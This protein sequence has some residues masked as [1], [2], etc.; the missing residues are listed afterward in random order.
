METLP[1]R[2]ATPLILILVCCQMTASSTFAR[3]PTFVVLTE[4]RTIQTF[5][6]DGMLLAECALE[7]RHDIPYRDAHVADALVDRPGDELVLLRN[8]HKLDLYPDP[9]EQAGELKRIGFVNLGRALGADGAPQERR[10]S[11]ALAPVDYD[12]NGANGPEWLSMTWKAGARTEARYEIY[13]TLRLSSFMEP[14]DHANLPPTMPAPAESASV[15][16]TSLLANRTGCEL[17]CIAGGALYGVGPGTDDTSLLFSRPIRETAPGETLV[18][19]RA[20][21]KQ[22]VLLVASGGNASIEFYGVDGTRKPERVRTV[23]LQT[24]KP[25]LA[26][27]TPGFQASCDAPLRH[28]LQGGTTLLF[29]TEAFPGAG[30]WKPDTNAHASGN[31]LLRVG[32][33]GEAAGDAKTLV[34]IP[35]EGKYHVWARGL[36]MPGNQ[37]GTRRFRVIVD[38]ELSPGEGGRHGRDG[39]AWDRVMTVHLEAGRHML[40][41]HDSA[42]FYA[43]ADAVLLTTTDMNPN[44]HSMEQLVTYRKAPEPVKQQRETPLADLPVPQ[45]ASGREVARLQ[46]DRLRMIFEMRQA[47]DGSE[48]IVR[49]TQILSDRKVW[50]ESVSADSERLFVLYAPDIE[51]YYRYFPFWDDGDTIDLKAQG[52]SYRIKAPDQDNP[53]TAGDMTPFLPVSARRT[54]ETTVRVDY[55]ASDGQTLI[56][57]WHLEPDRYDAEVEVAYT[58]QRTGLYSIGFTGFQNWRQDEIE[59]LHLPPV[60]QYQRLPQ[61]PRLLPHTYMPHPLALLQVPVQEKGHSVTVALAGDTARI[62][63]QWPKVDNT[64]YGFS[65]LNSEADPQPCIFTPVLGLGD[66]RWQAGEQHTVGWRVLTYPGEWEEAFEYFSESMMKVEDYRS[67]VNVSLTDA[68]L[69]MIELMRDK[70]HAGWDDELKG[71]YN[72]EIKGTVTQ[73][74]P[75]A[76]LSA[77]ILARDEELYASRAL[78]TIAYTLSRRGPHFG[79]PDAE[80]PST[81]LTIP[82]RAYGTPYWEGVNELLGH[83]NPWMVREFA[84]PDGEARTGRRL[85]PSYTALLGAWRADPSP[86]RLD[87]VRRKADAYIRKNYH[88]RFEKPLAIS[89]FSNV[90]NYPYWWDLVDLYEIT[91]ERDYLDYAAEGGFHTMMHLWSHPLHPSGTMRIHEGGQI[92]SIAGPMLKGDETY[93]LGWPRKPGDTPERAVPAWQV[94]PVGLGIENN[95]T[96]VQ[97]KKQFMRNIMMENWAPHLLRLF[98]HTGRDIYRTYARNSIIGRFA[99][100]PGYYLAMFTDLVQDPSYP[101]TGPD[102]TNIYYHHI[103]PHLMFSL[104]YLV[105]Q[106]AQR[107]D[108]AV[109]FP[110]AKQQNYVWFTNRVYGPAAGTICG[111]KGAVLWL[112]KDLLRQ[113]LDPR[114]DWLAARSENRFFLIL[115][116]QADAT[117]KLPLPLNREKVGLA[118]GQVRRYEGSRSRL[119]TLSAKEAA[120]VTLPARG[121][122][123]LSFP[124]EPRALFPRARAL[125][126]GHKARKIDSKWGTLHAFRIRTPFGRDSLYM[127]LTG[128]PDTADGG[129]TFE[130][131][132]MPKTRHKRKRFPYESTVYPLPMERDFTIRVQLQDGAETAEAHLDI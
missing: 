91:G 107:S 18:S 27:T 88:R 19:V 62:P 38:G 119:R 115:M 65:L 100:Y 81:Q 123:T 94:S 70:A 102:V 76:V 32:G 51:L 16:I 57:T 117:L 128:G 124:A 122:V 96:L 8:D 44:E 129:V 58:P 54:D 98:Q 34:D 55:R 41:L 29:E 77:A 53:F 101:Y 120:S 126:N 125:Q 30:G 110:Y 121:I 1:R 105:A 5:S 104:D 131:S 47:S 93:R 9:R 68:V 92:K 78:P 80:K 127:C 3:Q 14:M 106:A 43:R 33:E 42:R 66:S 23:Q 48:Q 116:S 2:L 21:K 61:R 17:A 45:S 82:T 39:F 71:F 28:Q 25:V 49:R 10:R 12:G 85:G 59:F 37:P 75:L 112:E 15:T 90:G 109:E 35:V 56:A 52:E 113:S 69:N 4:A 7:R 130:I 60:Y 24:N 97:V 67:P 11:I 72:I 84:L 22:L 89:H 83:L 74:A 46:N 118:G 50:R 108:G 114:V 40:G 99:N 20:R 64:V 13:P 103:P 95:V 86:E 132:G 36:D 79:R 111:E 31:A 6:D 87:A 63:Y 73:A 26:F